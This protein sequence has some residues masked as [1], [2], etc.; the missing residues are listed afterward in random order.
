MS[1]QLENK[2][3]ILQWT[4]LDKKK[5]LVQMIATKSRWN[6]RWWNWNEKANMEQ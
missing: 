6:R 4:P 2:I 1:W 3:Y 5:K